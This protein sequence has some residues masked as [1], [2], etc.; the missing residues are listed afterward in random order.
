MLHKYLVVFLLTLRTVF[1]DG[2]GGGVIV[3]FDPTNP[4]T[5]PFPADSL[6]VP[7]TTE[8]TGKRVNLPLPDC[9][10]LPTLC[11]QLALINQLDGF[12]I[13]PR[14]TVAFSGPV[15]TSTLRAGIFFV[16]LDN[17]TADEIGLQRT[18]DTVA[19]NQVVYDPVTNTVYAKPD[20]S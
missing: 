2:A 4:Q 17:L 11:G 9:T 15:D 20:A 12:N 13:Q 18:G 10:A 1:A 8:I 5:G 16:A 19:I 6:T 14:I 7:D 3:R